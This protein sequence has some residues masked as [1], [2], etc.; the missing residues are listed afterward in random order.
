MRL[1]FISPFGFTPKATLSHRILP[2]AK[3]LT[4]K[5][6]EI[7]IVIPPYTNPEASGCIEER[8]GVKLVNISLPGKIFYSLRIGIRMAKVVKRFNPDKVFVFKPKGYGALAAMLLWFLGK[9]YPLILD[10]DDLEFDKD[11]EIRMGYGFLTKCFFRCEERW[12]LKRVKG[13]TAASR[14]LAEYYGKKAGP[15]RVRYLPNGPVEVGGVEEEYIQKEKF[16]DTGEEI[17][18]KLGIQGK[19]VVLLYTRFTECYLEDIIDFTEAFSKKYPGGILLVI[20]EGYG[21]EREKILD[22]L[23]NKRLSD[24]V[25]FSGWVKREEL[26]E[27]LSVGEAAIYPMADTPFNRAKCSA[28]LIELMTMGMPI[29]ASPVGEVITYTQDGKSGLLAKD[30]IEMVEKVIGLLQDREKAKILGCKTRDF[31]YNN[32]SWNEAVKRL[33]S[34]IA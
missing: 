25:K 5:G 7:T 17:K 11:M 21:D 10:I 16:Q 4:K 8:A 9:R 20:G 2:I 33:G 12:L 3:A 24:F 32:F 26:K 31:I 18:K 30:T 22:A 1:A 13:I 19:R 15:D 14:F 29:V 6:H 23:K 27:Y 34:L 28:K